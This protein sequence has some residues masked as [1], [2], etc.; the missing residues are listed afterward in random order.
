MTYDELVNLA[1]ARVRDAGRNIPR[2]TLLR[3]MGTTQA[4]LFAT[5]ATLNPEYYGLCVTATLASGGVDLNALAPPLNQA[6]GIHRV[7]V[8]ASSGVGAP[9]AGTRIALVP[10]MD[11]DSGLPPRATVRDNVFRGVGSD[12]AAVTEI[13]V[14]YSRLSNPVLPTQGGLEAE[15]REPWQDLLLLDTALHVC[16]LLAA[17]GRPVAEGLVASITADFAALRDGWEAHVRG[18]VR[19]VDDR[20]RRTGGMA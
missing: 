1:L 3:R 15:L 8:A 7:E 17:E 19:D 13:R 2:A 18:Y 20:F 10:L 6:S 12:L 16:T 5:A 9:P 14:W 11:P 4:L